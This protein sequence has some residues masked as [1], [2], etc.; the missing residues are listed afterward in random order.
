MWDEVLSAV[1]DKSTGN[2]LVSLY[3]MQLEK[4]EELTY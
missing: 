4:S 3:K 2:I 1:T